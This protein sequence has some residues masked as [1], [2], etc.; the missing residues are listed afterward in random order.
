V[1]H[2]T[3]ACERLVSKEYKEGHDSVAKVVC[4]LLAE[5]SMRQK[6]ILYYTYEPEKVL[7]NEAAMIYWDRT[8]HTHKTLADNLAIKD[9]K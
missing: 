1:Q 5:R 3:G 4:G 2:I 8:L 6:R 9:K 7:E